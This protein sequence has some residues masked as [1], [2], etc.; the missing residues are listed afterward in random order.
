MTHQTDA[1]LNCHPGLFHGD[2]AAGSPEVQPHQV[3]EL[4]TEQ[5]PI[6]EPD[7]VGLYGGEHGPPVQRTPL[8]RH[9]QCR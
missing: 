1:P 4:G 8:C 9:P 3:F 6:G 2:A 5:A 7:A